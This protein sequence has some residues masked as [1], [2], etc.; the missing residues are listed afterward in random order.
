MAFHMHRVERKMCNP[1]FHKDVSFEEDRY[2][3]SE[4]SRKA[5]KATKKTKVKTM[6]QNQLADLYLDDITADINFVCGFDDCESPESV[7]AHKS[8]LSTCSTVLKTMFFGSLPET[9]DVRLRDVTADGF[10]KFLQFFYLDEMD[11]SMEDV[12]E[13]AYLAKKYDVDECFKICIQFIMQ[14]AALDDLCDAFEL[15]LQMDI[16]ELK[17]HCEW[18]IT[19]NLTFFLNTE[20]F[21]NCSTDVLRSILMNNETIHGKELFIGCL[22]WARN[23]WERRHVGKKATLHDIR[24]QLGEHFDLI[25][26]GSMPNPTITS[27]LTE[28][29]EFFTDKDRKK[30]F[31][32]MSTKYPLLWHNEK[33]S[34]IEIQSLENG[35][36]SRI[37]AI[38]VT[39]FR[40]STKIC[41][42]GFSYAKIFNTSI[43]EFKY[44]WVSLVK[45]PSNPD[46]EVELV[47]Y[48]QK[49]SCITRC[50]LQIYDYID[51]PAFGAIV[52]EPNTVYEIR[53]NFEKCSMDYTSMNSLI[54]S[55]DVFPLDNNEILAI[56]S[57]GL[58]KQLSFRVLEK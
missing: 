31:I 35:H 33:Q 2:K 17:A 45:K 15:A 50:Y 49:V 30:I 25:E 11:V 40:S 19:E 18:Q 57:F 42:V 16:P 7:P 13:I 47:L 22:N 21:P 1:I 36:E 29:F 12:A 53:I 24:S 44:G 39:S 46:D 56:Q 58:V 28:Y 5:M 54:P 9:G 27:L 37:N 38:E 41:L 8:I 55:N 43:N 52:I 3:A 14:V 48:R 20:E 23:A 6:K 4:C 10:K 51:F 34:T 32:I 26:Y